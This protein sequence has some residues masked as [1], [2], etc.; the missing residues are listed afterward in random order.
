MLSS[1]KNRRAAFRPKDI[2]MNTPIP[3]IMIAAVWL[4]L[5]AASA[6]ADEVVSAARLQ[7]QAT[8]EDILYAPDHVS[9]QI[10]NHGNKR[11]DNVQILVTY[12]W[13]WSDD[14]RTDE[15]APGWSEFHTLAGAIAPNGSVAFSFPHQPLQA[16]R[17]DGHFL[18]SVRIVGFTEFENP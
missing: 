4:T 14:R 15:D 5:N 6:P 10:I 8:V 13:L 16:Q 2:A 7:S 11:L 17:D 3:A 9:G 12:A 1:S 18:S